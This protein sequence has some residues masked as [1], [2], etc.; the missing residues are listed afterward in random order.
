MPNLERF[1]LEGCGRLQSLP[2]L[3]GGLTKLRVLDILD[4]GVHELPEDFGGPQS[5]VEFNARRFTTFI[6]L[7]QWF[8]QNLER[9]AQDGHSGL[10]RLPTTFGGLTKL[11]VLNISGSGVQRL[12]EDFGRLQSL[13]EFNARRFSPLSRLPDS[14]R[15]LPNL[16]KSDLEGCGRLQSLPTS[17]G[18][19]TKLRVLNISGSGVQEL[20]E[21][22]GRLQSL[23]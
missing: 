16:E 11:R 5:L 12:P 17:F 13:V 2:T 15:Q 10:Q 6:E 20:P 21:D 4:S 3:F 7:W 19:L 8:G 18:G 23:V 14:L 22:F 1:A 9:M